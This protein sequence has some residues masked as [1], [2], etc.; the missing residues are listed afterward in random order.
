MVGARIT[1]SHAIATALS[2]VTL[3]LVTAGCGHYPDAIRSA[4]DI[5][6]AAASE[7]MVVIVSLPLEDWSKLRKFTALEHFRISQEMASQINDDHIKALSRLKLPKLRDVSL[8]YCSKVTD[9]GLQA[10]ANIPSIQSLQ[11]IGLS[12]TD[13]GMRTLAIGFP[14]LTGINV[15][16]CRLLT[17]NGFSSLTGSTT[18][19]R[20]GM[21]F[22]PFSQEQIEKIISTVS[23]VTWW[24]IGDPRHRLDHAS[25]RQLGESRK[26]TIQVVDENNLVK[27]ITTA[28]PGGPANGS[29]PVHSETNQTSTTAGPHR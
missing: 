9:D 19:T 21:S 12:I 3:L 22:D 6:R 11:L 28:Q 18:I 29:Q 13:R 14:H 27:G 20:V 24:T 1:M 10:L 2:V 5:D 4:R 8:A 26:I 16:G 17:V 25:L 15:E 7:N 23:N